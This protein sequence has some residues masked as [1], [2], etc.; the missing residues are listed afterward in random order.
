VSVRL[1]QTTLL[2][3]T[4]LGDQRGIL[5][6]SRAGPVMPLQAEPVWI[7]EAAAVIGAE[8]V[9]VGA[10]AHG[11]QIGPNPRTPGIRGWP[12][13]RRHGGTTTPDGP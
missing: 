7:R 8:H 12:P 1:R 4:E 3:A 2:R 9:R 11:P 13:L 10:G 6:H 5:K